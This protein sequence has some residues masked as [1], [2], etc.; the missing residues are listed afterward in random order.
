MTTAGAPNVLQWQD[1]PTPTLQTDTDVLVR[2]YAAGVNP[3]DTKLRSRGTF[4]PDHGPAILGCDGAGVVAAIGTGVRS[5]QVGDEVYFCSG[6]LGGPY[7]NYAEYTIVDEQ[8]LA[9]KPKTLSFAEAAA[10]PLVLIT[11]WEALYDRGRLEAGRSVFVPA[12]AG[13]VGHVAIQ[14]AKLKDTRVATSVSTPEKAALVQRLGADRV[15]LYP[16]TDVVRSLLDWT[17]GDGVDLSFDTIGGRSL[18]Q[19]FAA[20]AIYG[21][22]VTILAPDAN[23]DWKTARDR[24]LRISYELMLTPMLKPLPSARRDQALILKQCARLIDQG[25]LHIHLSRTFPLAEAA[26]AH[27]CIE[28]GHT[29]GKIALTI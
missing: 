5:L 19:C 28:D 25:Q 24:N 4:Y 15:I 23:T 29:T 17:D 2:L 21:D 3:I 14:L 22:V 11:A 26:H 10:A 8:Y 12:G 13:G 20:T 6:G 7:G 1:V 27:T 9:P 16:E 18:S